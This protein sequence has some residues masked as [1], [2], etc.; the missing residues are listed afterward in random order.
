MSQCIHST[1]PKCLPRPR[2][3]A[4]VPIPT[5]HCADRPSSIYLGGSPPCSPGSTREPSPL[6]RDSKASTSLLPSPTYLVFQ[7]LDLSPF[8]IDVFIQN[9]ELT[10]SGRGGLRQPLTQAGHF[11]LQVRYHGVF[12]FRFKFKIRETADFFPQQQNDFILGGGQMGSVPG[13][14]L[15]RKAE[16]TF[17][18]VGKTRCNSFGR[19]RTGGE[20]KKQT[21]KVISTAWK[22]SQSQEFVENDILVYRLCNRGLQLTGT[23]NFLSCKIILSR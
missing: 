12:V 3:L 1:C 8:G 13:V 23:E 2:F 6:C 19:V 15:G 14:G 21:F 10:L 16:P 9:L 11:V 18:N 7:A 20:G 4:W 5:V 17:K 22:T